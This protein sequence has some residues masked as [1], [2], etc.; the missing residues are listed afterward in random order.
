MA[1][2]QKSNTSKSSKV[3]NKENQDIYIDDETI[4]LDSQEQNESINNSAESL[5]CVPTE[6]IKDETEKKLEDA[7][8]EYNGEIKEEHVE[9]HQI[10]IRE[11]SDVAKISKGNKKLIIVLSAVILVIL[12]ALITFGIVNKIN[13]NIYNNIYLGQKN[14]SKMTSAEL[15]DYL[16]KE[17]EKISKTSLKVMQDD[18]SI[19]EIMPSDIGF[20][21]DAANVEKQVFGYGRESNIVKNNIDIFYALIFK[22][23]F[24]L[25]YKYDVAKLS[26]IVKEIKESLDNK[27]IDDSYVVD[28]NQHKLIITRG[29]SGNTIEEDNVKNKIISSLANSAKEYKVEI[30][31]GT[32]EALD[33]DV[34]YSKV[35]REAKDAYIDKS[36][37]V[38]K[39]VP[40]VVGF[41]FDKNSL[42]N[43][44]SKEENKTE[45]KVIEYE[46]TVLEPKVKTSDIKWEMYEYKISS[47]TTYFST[48]DP[49]RVNNLRVALNLLNGRVIMPGE[50]FSYNSVVG[51]ATAAQGFKAAAT[52]VGGRVVREVG[53]GICQTVSTLYNTA[54]LANLEI[55]QRKAHSLPVAYVPGS[56]DATVY[57]PS[58]DFKFK[59]TREYPIKIVTSFNSGGN[60][61]ISLYGTKQENEYVVSISSRTIS[62][63]PYTTQYV[64]DSSMAKGTQ[65]VVQN[66]SNGSKSEAY[67]TKKLNGK[68]VSTTL[69][70]RDTYKA[71]NRIVHVGT[72]EVSAPP[73]VVSQPNNNTGSNAGGNTNTG[74]NNNTNVDTGVTNPDTSSGTTATPDNSG[75]TETNNN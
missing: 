37:S 14:I 53:G 35:K 70:S 58:I 40:H 21:I 33:V 63:I 31:K 38:Y 59:N 30:V 32:P 39:F 71:V 44:L 64:N 42:N 46:L 13:S 51:G 15:S 60:L 2:K 55:V 41:D 50:T 1:R 6:T 54:L 23:E 29:K 17:Q 74:T 73:P 19:L 27:V 68:V 62:S 11:K 10:R 65:K 36:T 66:G 72:K 57:Y 24:D 25:V 45:G 69:L 28:E 26:E 22:K 20:E 52:F 67:I 4:E 48:S 47:Y 49:N 43:I 34:V 8:K 56:R 9:E 16:K 7:V 75:S 18:E 61:T 3:K 12:I 5:E